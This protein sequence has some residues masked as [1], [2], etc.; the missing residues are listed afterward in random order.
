MQIVIINFKE[1][2]FT[3][4]DFVN[5]TL[6]GPGRGIINYLGAFINAQSKTRG[7]VFVFQGLAD[8]VVVRDNSESAKKSYKKQLKEVSGQFPYSIFTSYCPCF[9]SCIKF[10]SPNTL[11][12]S[13]NGRTFLFQKRDFLINMNE[14]NKNSSEV[15]SLL[16]QERDYDKKIKDSR[17]KA[18]KEALVA[19]GI[20]ERYEQILT[21]TKANPHAT[22]LL[23]SGFGVNGLLERIE[24]CVKGQY[25][26]T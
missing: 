16:E 4:T 12:T 26:S 20:F 7:K 19:G 9:R 10:E 15:R 18:L 1:N 3:F 25:G 13:L 21:I 22:I 2:Y 8:V 6:S 24:K 17:K 5:N 23:D 11:Y 14:F